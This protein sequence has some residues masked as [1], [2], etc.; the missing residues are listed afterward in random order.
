VDDAYQDGPARFYSLT[1]GGDKGPT[2]LADK[3]E[4]ANNVGAFLQMEL[5]AGEHARF[6]LGA[7]YDGI[8]YSYQDRIDPALNDSRTFTHVTPKLGVAWLM[9]SGTIYLNL[10]GGTEV[11]AYN[12]VDPPGLGGLDT[13]TGLNPL[14]K[15]MTST[16]VEA[17]A[18]QRVQLGN[19]AENGLELDGALYVTDVYNDL[20]P[21]SGGRFYY[22]AGQTRRQGF[23]LG[24]AL[25]TAV[26]VSLRGSVTLAND[27][28]VHYVVD[29]VH[30][31]RPGATADFA[32]NEMPGV[33]PAFYAMELAWAPV[34]LRHVRIQAALQGN[35]SY[36]ADD[37]NTITVP[38]ATVFN[39]TI[40][41]STPIPLS[42]GVGLNAFVTVNN[43]ANRTYAASAYIN[44]DLVAGVPVYLE[45]GL[46]RNVVVSFS[47]SR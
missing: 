11:P 24:A 18:R 7:R 23:E 44:P 17:G 30:Y 9:R 46:P 34:Q 12:E 37:A 35:S 10:G 16:T 15:P 45:P 22:T 28:Y 31:G 32:G 3:T 14:L 13:L 25:A 5:G 1:P 4:A 29:S 6:L 39:A 42:A 36:F 8:A 38:S 20:I 27:R 2:L 19:N 21:Y 47:L 41:T 33:P 40:S 26:G 43:I